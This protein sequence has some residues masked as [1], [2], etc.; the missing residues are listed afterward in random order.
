MKD[1]I[2]HIFSN[3]SA[4]LINDSKQAFNRSYLLVTL[5]LGFITPLFVQAQHLDN[6]KRLDSFQRARTASASSILRILA[7][8]YNVT[9]GGAYCTG[10][11]GVAVG[12]DN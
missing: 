11:S 4:S 5:L 9:G 3:R 12:L 7:N 1:C 10:G 8:T 2:V 6:R